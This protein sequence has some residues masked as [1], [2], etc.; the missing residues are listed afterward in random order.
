MS[1]HKPFN[2][3]E[4]AFLQIKKQNLVLCQQRKRSAR[5][6]GILL[7]GTGLL[8]PEYT[9]IL[10]NVF[11]F[12]PREKLEVGVWMCRVSIVLVLHSVT[13]HS[14]FSHT[15]IICFHL[16][17]FPRRGMRDVCIL[18][19]L[20]NQWFFIIAFRECIIWNFKLK[21]SATALNFKPF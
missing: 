1:I 21:K 8:E 11:L 3:T 6:L 5:D 7:S 20:V 12:Y 16:A 19:H 13:P 9:D 10:I 15:P 14:T 4:Y 18:F 17:L 2:L